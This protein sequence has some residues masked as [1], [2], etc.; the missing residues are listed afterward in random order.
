M[1]DPADRLAAI[2]SAIPAEFDAAILTESW[3]NDAWL[4]DQSVLRVCWR[5]DRE[6]LA[7]EQAILE[8]LPSSVP[9]A[10]VLAAGRTDGLTWLTA[11]RIP[12]ERLDLAWPRLTGQQR[13]DAIGSL[14]AAMKALHGWEP[15]PRLRD[16]LRLSVDTAAA[17]DEIAGGAVVPMPAP[18][19]IPLLDWLDEQPALGSDLARQVRRRISDLRPV[20]A[21]AEFDDGVVVHGDAHLANVLWHEGKVV[22]LLDFEWARLGP[23]DLEF[24]AVCRDNADIGERARQ[25]VVPAA[26]VPVLAGLRSGYPELFDQENLTERVWLYELCHRVRQLCLRDVFVVAPQVLQE[27][28]DLVKH[29]RVGFS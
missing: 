9:H 13:H 11:R 25:G 29:P 6:R 27:L 10:S 15:P 3:S 17:H 2:R 8:S 24:E 7:R 23:P 4:T 12:G 5:G 22:A 20:I 26:A 16:Q 21:D 14:A 28:T 18:R 1:D 19:L